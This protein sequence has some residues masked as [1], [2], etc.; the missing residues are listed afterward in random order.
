MA[1]IS[2]IVQ[3]V[4]TTDQHLHCSK[5]TSVCSDCHQPNSAAAT[6]QSLCAMASTTSLIIRSYSGKRQRCNCGQ[7]SCDGGEKGLDT[8]K[9][10]R[11]EAKIAKRIY[12][13]MEKRSWDDYHQQLANGTNDE[14]VLAIRTA[15]GDGVSHTLRSSSECII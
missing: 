6:G 15:L 2:S 13:D 12:D 14:P 9:R 3:P 4:I 11:V 10:H 7:S 1:A 5:S 8:I